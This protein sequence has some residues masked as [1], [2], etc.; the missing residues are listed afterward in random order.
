MLVIAISTSLHSMLRRRFLGGLAAGLASLAIVP[1]SSR[2]TASRRTPY[3]LFVLLGGGLDAILTLDPKTRT[4]VDP[5]VDLP[6]DARGIHSTGELAL[7]PHMVPLAPW[8]GRATVLRGVLTSSVAHAPATY[9]LL[10]MRRGIPLGGKQVTFL[11]LVA[12]A[13]RTAQFPVVRFGGSLPLKGMITSETVFEGLLSLSPEE[14][15]VV[16]KQLRKQAE[17]LAGSRDR[18]GAATASRLRGTVEFLDRLPALPGPAVE[19]WAT[20][21][22]AQE[23]AENLQRCLWLFEH[24]LTACA[25]VQRFGWDTHVD[26]HTAQGRVSSELLPVLA[27]FVAELAKRTNAHGSLLDQV[28]IIAGSEL[29]R[30]PKLNSERG[31]HHFPEVPML[32]MGAGIPGGR[33]FG[34]TGRMMEAL[35]IDLHSGRATGNG[36]SVV[37]LDDV[38]ATLL[39]SVGVDPELYGN[40]GRHLPFLVP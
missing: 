5:S 8:V 31:K 22:D 27:R 12:G 39:R 9:Q 25:F 13:H 38:G 14:L 36:G 16:R 24:D 17:W 4:E 32:F 6:Y 1:R 30:F 3:H 21:P 18:E 28:R 34:R 37:T 29:G 33:A 10:L 23:F 35:P 20:A 2:A 11:D 40:S 7:G 26:N 15:D 19:A